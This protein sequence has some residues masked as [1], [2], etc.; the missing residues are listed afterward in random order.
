MPETQT[1]R[2]DNDS[3]PMPMEGLD[4]NTVDPVFQGCFIDISEH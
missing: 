2:A 3:P 4:S 1:A